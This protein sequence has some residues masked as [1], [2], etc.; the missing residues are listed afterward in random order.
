MDKDIVNSFI[1][2]RTIW[3]SAHGADA[4]RSPTADCTGGLGRSQ[5]AYGEVLRSAHRNRCSGGSSKRFSAATPD[6]NGYWS[7]DG[8]DSQGALNQRTTGETFRSWAIPPLYMRKT[9]TLEAYLP[10]LYLKDSGWTSTMKSD[11]TDR[12]EVY[13]HSNSYGISMAI[14]R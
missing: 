12:S 2:S 9:R 11:H 8:V 4:K 7:G 1:S 5:R 10:W 14:N 3:R 6:S 13:R